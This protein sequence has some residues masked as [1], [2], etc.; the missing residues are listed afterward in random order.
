MPKFVEQANG[1]EEKAQEGAINE[2]VLP[3]ILQHLSVMKNAESDLY[4]KWKL[5]AETLSE[6]EQV[7]QKDLSLRFVLLQLGFF[8]YCRHPQDASE[9]WCSGVPLSFACRSC[10]EKQWI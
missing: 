9:M 2:L 7:I 5:E 4:G 3:H 8:W 6:G 1:E 10:W